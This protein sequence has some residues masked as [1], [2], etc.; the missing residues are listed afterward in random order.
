[1]AQR[2]AP[3]PPVRRIIADK[4]Y[5]RINI[6]GADDQQKTGAMVS[7]TNPVVIVGDSP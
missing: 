7:T 1:L 4:S 5:Y 6:V 3:R 2:T